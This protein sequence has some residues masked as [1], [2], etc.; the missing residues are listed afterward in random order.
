MNKLRPRT[1]DR[2]AAHD[3]KPATAFSGASRNPKTSLR[4]GLASLAGGY[5]ETL[6][7]GP[8]GVGHGA[9]SARR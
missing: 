3:R 4:G 7:Y 2:Y 6:D 5:S 8:P 9:A 1:G